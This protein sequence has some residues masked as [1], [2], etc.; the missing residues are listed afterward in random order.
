M[1]ERFL[2]IMKILMNMIF[3][4]EMFS[5]PKFFGRRKGRVVR[6]AKSFLLEAMLPQIRVCQKEDFD[7]DKLFKKEVDK[8]CLEIGF[9]D[10]QHIFIDGVFIAIGHRPNTD[11]LDG[12][13]IHLNERGYIIN[14]EFLCTSDSRIYAA[15]DC[16]VK[17]IRQVLTAASD[18]ARAALY[19]NRRV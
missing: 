11:W 2:L 5:E 7:K 10:G 6:K 13:L 14:D 8:L 17:D 19:I 16:R 4:K 3:N 15:G 9:G 12:S 18:G 1:R